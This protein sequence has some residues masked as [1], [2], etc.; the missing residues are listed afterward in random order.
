MPDGLW[1]SSRSRD[2]HV[3]VAEWLQVF[4]RFAYIFTIMHL[5]IKT[6]NRSGVFSTCP[7]VDMRLYDVTS[8]L[9]KW[10]FYP[11]ISKSNFASGH[12]MYCIF[13]LSSHGEYTES[14]IKNCQ[15]CGCS[16]KCFNNVQVGCVEI[17]CY[18]PELRQYTPDIMSPSLCCGTCLIV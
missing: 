5:R 17:S 10:P 3:L 13:I 14:H 9:T 15:I 6:A 16:W 8:C 12:K 11:H 1:K 2:T 7:L 18:H 4:C